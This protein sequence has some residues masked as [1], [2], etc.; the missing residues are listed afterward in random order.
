ML[1][2]ART[3]IV[4]VPYRWPG[5]VTDE[6]I[7]DPVDERMLTEWTGARPV[8]TAI[9]EDLGMRRLIAVYRHIE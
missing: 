9:V 5:W 3:A 8:E 4:S 2:A 7:N 1:G 6:H